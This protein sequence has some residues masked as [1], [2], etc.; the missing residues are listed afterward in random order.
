MSTIGFHI[1]FWFDGDNGVSN[2]FIHV[3]SMILM[4]IKWFAH[5]NP[6]LMSTHK[7]K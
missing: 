6:R 4:K 2:G 5:P 7:N 3:V 1:I